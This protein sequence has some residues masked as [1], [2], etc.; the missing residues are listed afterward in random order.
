MNVH[1]KPALTV[2]SDEAIADLIA[3]A[4]RRVIYMAPGVS[5]TIAQALA[6]KMQELG[7]DAVAIIVDVDP[8]ICRMGYGEIDALSRL[9]RAATQLGGMVLAQPGVRIGLVIADDETLV[10][11]PTPLLI[12]AG[13]RQSE[14]IIKPNAVRLGLPPADLERDLGAGPDGLA[15]QSIGLDKAERAHIERAQQELKENPPQRFDIS[16]CVRVFNARFEFVELSLTGAALERKSVTLPNSLLGIDTEG[17]LGESL[18]ARLK[19]IEPDSTLSGKHLLKQ[20]RR[21]VQHYLEHLPGYGFIVRRSQKQA[22]ISEVGKL[23]DAAMRF[24]QEVHQQIGTQLEAKLKALVDILLPI[25]AANP[26]ADL[27]CLVSD[28]DFRSIVTRR[29]WQ[30]IARIHTLIKPIEVR[31]VF[32]GVAYESLQDPKFINLVRE[33]LIDEDMLFEEYDAAS[34]ALPEVDEPNARKGAA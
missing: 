21:I 30:S 18:H 34:L 12:E 1:G 15:E 19:L 29:V 5:M 24:E 27:A 31:L 11:S 14:N 2:A 8:E 3:T 33:R 10:F 23:R 7:A 28:N 4:E 17:P 25:V 16:R 13:P 6:T 20:K 32:K 9:E 22:L 26:P